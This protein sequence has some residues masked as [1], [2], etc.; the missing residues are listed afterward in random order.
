[1][2][3]DNTTFHALCEKWQ[4]LD[5][6]A[7]DTEFIRVNTFYPK[8]GLIQVCDNQNSY[9]IDPLIITDWSVFVQI[10]QDESVVKILHSCSEDLVVF[11]HFF[12]TI[13][14]S[15]FDTQKA[16][17][18]LN[19]GFSL[20]YQ[21]LVKTL[22]QIDVPKGETRSDWL[23]RPLSREQLNY[24]ALDVAY[25][26]EVYRLLRNQLLQ[27]ER[28]LWLTKDCDQM[29]HISV[30][31]ENAAGWDDY[32]KNLGAGWRLDEEQAGVLRELCQWREVE[33]RHRDKPRSWIAK[34]TD[35]I[36]I[37]TALPNTIS[38]LRDIADLPNALFNHDGA[39]LLALVKTGRQRKA[40]IDSF[41]KPLTP[42]LR[43]VLKKM[44]QA[45]RKV[46]ADMEIA[47]E[48]LARKKLLVDLLT[49][50]NLTGE[51]LWPAE[52]SAWRREVLEAEIRA[53]ISPK[54]SESP[55]SLLS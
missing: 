45:V 44:Q 50:F 16:A 23:R 55:S 13:P 12:N 54:S 51:L 35:F 21:N 22:L 34:D 27:R 10:L 28:L 8:L 11:H 48:L 40:S 49:H 14:T 19:L 24:A 15:L 43:H 30:N 3:T 18:Y 26:P 2:I 20:S 37:A 33:A 36:A 38:D 47:E 6:L 41:E 53:A 52:V 39:T 5:F 25:L 29:R 32:Y 31:A 42:D 4:H 9:L 17:A 7:L 1:M 46:A